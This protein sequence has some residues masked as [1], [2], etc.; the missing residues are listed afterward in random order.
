ML[1]DDFTFVDLWRKKLLAD[2]EEFLRNVARNLRERE[3]A[4]QRPCTV[5]IGLSGSGKFPNYRIEPIME[6]DEP[7]WAELAAKNTAFGGKSH[8]VQMSGLL[9]EHWSRTAMTT[10]QADMLRQAVI[11]EKRPLS[12]F[13]LK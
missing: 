10:D 3:K 13:A 6:G 7:S 9:S 8:K 4:L 11:G 12:R 2:P 5:R 1:P